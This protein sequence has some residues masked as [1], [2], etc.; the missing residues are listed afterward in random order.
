MELRFLPLTGPYNAPAFVMHFEHVAAGAFQ[1][2]AEQPLEDHGHVGHEIH[3]IVVNN[4]HPWHGALLA[5]DG[6]C[7]FIGSG[8]GGG[9][10]GWIH[11]ALG[12]V[13]YMTR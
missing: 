9:E 11:G 13:E 8:D 2:E 10:G 4:D 12:P 3:G 1:G 7:L 6:L 5:G